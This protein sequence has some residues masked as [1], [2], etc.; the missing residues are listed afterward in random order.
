MRMLCRKSKATKY[1]LPDLPNLDPREMNDVNE[2]A[3]RRWIE[4]HWQEVGLWK[5]WVASG[6][7]GFGNGNGNGN[8]H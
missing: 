5:M 7:D 3:L 8:G 1:P 4:E 2:K 6:E